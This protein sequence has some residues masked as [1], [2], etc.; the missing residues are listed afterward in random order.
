MSAPSA[1]RAR[2]ADASRLRARS[3]DDVLPA[4]AVEDPREPWVFDGDV[5]D[6]PLPPRP[7][8]ARGPYARLP[9][10]VLFD[11]DGTLVVDVPYNGDPDRVTLM[12]GAAEAVA[13]V[14]SLG[15]PVGV[16]SNQSGV[17][18]GLI[19]RQDV[20][21]VRRRVDE[22]LGP[23]AVWA[24]CPHGPDDGCP[25][26]KP[27]PGLVLAACARLGVRPSR[28]VVIGDIGADVEAARAAGARG[29]LVPTPVTLPGEIEAAAETAA[30]LP[31]TVRM[32]LLG[33][34]SAAGTGLRGGVR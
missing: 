7:G 3:R 20:E 33:T 1:A 14:R 16:V 28:T 13:A 5:A 34:D 8:W 21:A 12:P 29:I 30:D 17:A 24:V 2:P 6:A 4:G 11:R 19:T 27:A 25:C 23:F 10:A 18:R 15:I 26:R 32:I 22:R 9:E 31:A